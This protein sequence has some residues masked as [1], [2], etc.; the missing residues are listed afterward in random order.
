MS[1]VGSA[2]RPSRGKVWVPLRAGDPVGRPLAE[3]SYR[4]PRFPMG[5]K[6]GDLALA[7]PEVQRETMAVWFLA[8]HVPADGPYFGF[9]E[10]TSQGT[11]AFNTQPFNT[12][13]LASGVTIGGWGQAPF[14]NGG[15]S[16]DLLQAEFAPHVTEA[17]ILQ[18]SQSFEGLWERLPFDAYLNLEDAS[19]EELRAA[20]VAALD[21]FLAMLNAL[22]PRH[23]GIGH[24]GP[25]GDVVPITEQERQIALTATS[26]ARLAVLSDEYET[27]AVV[28]EAASPIL[29]KIGGFIASQIKDFLAG[30]AKKLGEMAAL[31][32][33]A[34]AS[35]SLILPWISAHAVSEIL[36]LL[37][38]L[39]P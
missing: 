33:L 12:A 19:A 2:H 37:K 20:A 27:A 31:G 9:A 8:N 28:W 7:E 22:S 32:L 35:V 17:A 34:T 38:H 1:N 5:I 13:P 4:T 21:Q 10:S 6:G 16:S 3:W 30:F 39:R 36:A 23:G 29:A 14:F 24:N 26:E 11:G 25:P 18:L 15:R